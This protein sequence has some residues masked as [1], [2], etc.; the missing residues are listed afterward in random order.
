MM[1]ALLHSKGQLRTERY[2]DTEKGCQKP[3]VPQKT[4]GDGYYLLTEF[5]NRVPNG[6]H[7]NVLLT[8]CFH[9]KLGRAKMRKVL[10]RISVVTAI[11]SISAF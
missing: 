3:A 7:V 9:F 11:L 6:G 2:G 10:N 5:S 8:M 4:T 1:V